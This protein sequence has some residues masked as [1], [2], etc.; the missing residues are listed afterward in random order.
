MKAFQFDP[1]EFRQLYADQGW[2]H[3]PSGVD[4]QFL[5]A[6]RK[7]VARS[8]GAQKVE[9]P[10]IGGKGRKDQAVF[11]F[12]D[13]EEVP[14]EVFDVIAALS[15][16]DRSTLTLSERHVNAYYSDAEPEPTAHK[17]RHSSQI[18]VGLTI[19][20][21]A[22][23]R[24]ALYPLD[25]R[26]ENPFNVS[27]ALLDSLPADR[28]PDEVL[29]GAH[30]VEI[31]DS[32]GDVIAFPGSSV[33]HLRRRPAGA[34]ILYLKMNDFGSDPL[35][36]DPTTPARRRATLEALEESSD[37]RLLDLVP[38]LARRLDTIT[39]RYLRDGWRRLIEAEVWQQK[40]V[41]LSEWELGFL[42]EIDGRRTLGGL[43]GELGSSQEDATLD[44][45]R[46]LALREVIDLVPGPAR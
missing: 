37:G 19:E 41:P 32:P 21:P 8:L 17:D 12:P 44:R 4:P 40:P 36:E 6:M 27:F 24:V 2:V 26:G 39:E 18:S 9:G 5:D 15:G 23:S 1:A 22:E 35:G 46:E 38:V 42:R 14:S 13:S 3:I 29:R 11:E 7:F 33:W 25:D 30:A 10:G 16:L 31:D 20:S 28:Q 34:V 45:V 43:L